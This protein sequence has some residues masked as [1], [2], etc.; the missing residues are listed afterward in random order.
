MSMMRSVGG[1]IRKGIEH[2]KANRQQRKWQKAERTTEHPDPKAGLRFTRRV[3]KI[4]RRPKGER[5][6]HRQTRGLCTARLTRIAYKTTDTSFGR[7]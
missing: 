1:F 4:T 2:Y 5:K 7:W 6:I 3:R